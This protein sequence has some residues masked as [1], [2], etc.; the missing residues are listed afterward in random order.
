MFSSLFRNATLKL[1][2]WYLLII[3]IVSVLFSIL[4]YQ[5]ASGE[6]RARLQQ[7]GEGLP[8]VFFGPDTD[9]DQL[10]DLRSTQAIQASRNILI[11]LVYINLSVLI[12][13]GFASYAMARRTLKPLADAHE[14]ESRFVGNASHELKTPLTAMKTELEVALHDPKLAKAEM[15]SL[16]RSNL[17]EVNKLTKLSES[18]LSL[19]KMEYDKL[20]FKAMSLTAITKSAIRKYD[21]TGRIRLHEEH[22]DITVVAHQPAIEELVAILI[23][24][25]RKYSPANSPIDITLTKRSTKVEFV[26]TNTGEGIPAKDL[27]HIF[28]RFYRVD[29][30]RTQNK[31]TSFGLG[32]SLAK[33]IIELHSGELMASSVPGEITTFRFSLPHAKETIRK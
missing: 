13:G 22:S 29:S 18:L 32:L 17:E 26:I 30:A 1:T 7:F 23:D 33:Q 3:M 25:A 6:V 27:P 12:G 31:K 15:R 16:L 11:S 14:A 4:I 28:D 20:D 24:N 2:G 10:R 19:S 9:P 8:V 21:D 5:S